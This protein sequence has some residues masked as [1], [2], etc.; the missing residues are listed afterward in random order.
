MLQPYVQSHVTT[1][2]QSSFKI[3]SMSVCPSS[4][5]PPR[6][7]ACW[8]LKQPTSRA[9][10]WAQEATVKFFTA[11][12]T[13][14]VRACT[15]TVPHQPLKINTETVNATL[16]LAGV[17]DCVGALKNAAFFVTQYERTELQ[18]NELALKK[19]VIPLLISLECCKSS[20]VTENMW[21]FFCNPCLSL[22]GKL[23][24]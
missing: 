10:T 8:C 4:C 22:D 15:S 12:G 14:S 24:P 3:G 18:A 17:C 21:N 19:M 13:F 2:H 1:N 20:L 6:P 7:S 23:L 9:R 16:W 5:S 11:D